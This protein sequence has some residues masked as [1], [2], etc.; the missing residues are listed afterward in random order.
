MWVASGLTAAGGDSRFPNN[1]EGSNRTFPDAKR[2]MEAPLADR[3]ETGTGGHMQHPGGRID[4][5]G[6]W[7]N[8]GHASGFSMRKYP[9]TADAQRVLQHAADSPNVR[10]DGGHRESIAAMPSRRIPFF[11]PSSPSAYTH[12][13]LLPLSKGVAL[14]FW[15]HNW[16]HNRNTENVNH[17]A[18]IVSRPSVI[19]LTPNAF[20]KGR[21]RKGTAFCVSD[22]EARSSHVKI[23][24]CLWAHPFS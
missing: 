13:G 5:K 11:T 1:P 14:H 2:R 6:I 15:G 8:G 17:C 4:R 19:V 7:I 21:S 3:T 24:G 18:A 20:R 10:N 9:A 22:T 16:G 12:P 23:A